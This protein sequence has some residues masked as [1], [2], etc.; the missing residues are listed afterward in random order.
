M[1]LGSEFHLHKSPYSA[2]PSFYFSRDQFPFLSTRVMQPLYLFVCRPKAKNMI[3][4]C[5]CTCEIIPAPWSRL[6]G[7]TWHV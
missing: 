6:V 7:V 3:V 2:S 4:L 5:E 1:V